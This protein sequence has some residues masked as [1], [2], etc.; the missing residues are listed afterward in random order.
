M[1]VRDQAAVG[2]SLGAQDEIVSQSAEEEARQALTD[3]NES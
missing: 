2:T 3:E 1:V